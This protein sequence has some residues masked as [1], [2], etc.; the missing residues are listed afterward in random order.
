[1]MPPDSRAARIFN[2][3]SRWALF[4]FFFAFVP[5]IVFPIFSVGSHRLMGLIAASAVLVM[6]LSAV[7][8]VCAMVLR[9]A[10]ANDW[11]FSLRAM[12]MAT[13]LIAIVLGLIV[14]AV[15]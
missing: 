11:R 3:I 13:T 15:R 4:A 9:D 5:L 8:L 12:L 14:W 7:T 10:A 2:R 1:M 6:F